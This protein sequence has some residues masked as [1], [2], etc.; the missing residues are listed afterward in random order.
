MTKDMTTG[1][2]VKLI[3]SFAIP[4]FLGMLFQQFYSM[5]DTVIVGKY[6]GVNPLAG[7][8]STSSLNFM[9]IGFCTGVCNG[10]AIPVAQMFGAREESRL[11]RFVANSTW[12]CIVFSV[13]M[14]LAV[15]AVCRPVLRLMNTPEEIFEY[16]YIYIVIIFW[17]IPCTFLY[18]I[19]AGIIRSLGD[20]RTPVVFLAISSAFNIV[21]DFVSILILHMNVEGPALA[22]VISQGISGV[23]CLFYMKKKYPILKASREEWKPDGKYMKRLCFMGIPMG[24]QYSVTAIGTLVLQAAINGLGAAVVAGVTAAQKIN[25]FISCPVESLGQTMAPYTGQNMGAGKIDR[26]GKGLRDASLVG[27]AMSS[28]CF[29]IALLTGKQLC[30]LFLDASETEIIAYAYE[31]LLFCTGGYCLLTLVNTVRFTIQGMGFSIFAITSGVMEMIARVLAS[32]V[33][34]GKI[35]FI[36]ICLAHP[37]AW[38]FADAFLIPAFFYCKKKIVKTTNSKK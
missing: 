22:T 35:G 20:S 9:V 33:I 18:N 36:G 19:L 12:L 14:T 15:V 7:V 5:V 25:A 34:A 37:L 6:L 26:I 30:L 16:A 3:I 31:F 28:V 13:V 23:I 38:V 17:G 1:S 11:R 21:L 32:T 27:F 29:L 4:M 10:F 24:L 2:P 8:G